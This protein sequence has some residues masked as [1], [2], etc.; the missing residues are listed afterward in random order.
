MSVNGCT[1]A[2]YIHCSDMYRHVC[3]CLYQVVRIPDAA[4]GSG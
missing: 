4:G 1:I 3:T 2:W